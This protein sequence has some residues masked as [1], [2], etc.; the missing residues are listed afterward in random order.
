M[1]VLLAAHELSNPGKCGGLSWSLFNVAHQRSLPYTPSMWA[2]RNSL[3]G[4]AKELKKCCNPHTPLC[5]NAL[6]TTYTH[7]YD[8]NKL[9]HTPLKH[10]AKSWII[11]RSNPSQISTLLSPLE[12]EVWDCSEI[13]CWSQGGLHFLFT[14][15]SF[16]L[17][18]S[19]F[20]KQQ[21]VLQTACWCLVPVH[22]RQA[23]D[24]VSNANPCGCTYLPPPQRA[25]PLHLP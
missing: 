3:R 6:T 21:T 17:S 23:Q 11:R 15:S 7:T 18:L 25:K 10:T 2:F 24:T 9:I 4:F 16:P 13:S 8:S 5:P 14:I 20:S 1:S 12:S 19:L 22:T